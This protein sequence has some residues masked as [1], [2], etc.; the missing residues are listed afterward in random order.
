MDQ[1]KQSVPLLT[2]YLRGLDVW[3]L[4]L[5]LFISRVAIWLLIKIWIVNF[6]IVFLA[7]VAS[8]LICA[9][10][11]CNATNYPF[12]ASILRFA[13]FQAFWLAIDIVWQIIKAI[14]ELRAQRRGNDAKGT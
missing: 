11:I 5:T 3:A 10:Y 13:P 2:Q 8:L 4:V 7:N 14:R 12:L 6:T 1:L 9:A